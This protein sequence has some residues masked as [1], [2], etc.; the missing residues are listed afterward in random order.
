M[1]SE[2]MRSYRQAAG[3]KCSLPILV[4]RHVA[5]RATSFEKA[6]AASRHVCSPIADRSCNR[7]RLPIHRWVVA[8][9]EGRP[10][11]PGKFEVE[12]GMKF[13]P[14]RSDACLPM[15]EIKKSNTLDLDRNTDGLENWAG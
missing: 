3:S 8:G 15:N 7:D 13:N 11:R 1:R 12:N 5:H 9:C 4:Q 6:D 2:G 14:V 10:R